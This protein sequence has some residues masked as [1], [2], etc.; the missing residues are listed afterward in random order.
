MTVTACCMYLF[1]WAARAGHPGLGLYVKKVGGAK[2]EETEAKVERN[3]LFI[4]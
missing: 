2:V 4:N 3:A 1:S